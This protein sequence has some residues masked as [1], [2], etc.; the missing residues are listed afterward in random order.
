MSAAAFTATL[1]RRDLAELLAE[2]RSRTVLLVS[3]LSRTDL[4]LRPG[5]AV[6]T[7]MEELNDIVRFEDRLL[8]G[9]SSQVDADSSSYDEWFDRMVEVRQRAL[10]RL[11]AVQ[12]PDPWASI[13]HRTRMAVEH[14]YRRGEAI[15]E[16]LQLLGE[17]YRAPRRTLLPRG[18]R[19]ADPGAMTR[20]PGG[21]VELGAAPGTLT[22]PDE[23]PARRLE[24][25]PFWMDVLPVTNGEY[26]TFMAAGGYMES[27]LWSEAGW[28]WVRATE[29]RMPAVWIWEDGAWWTRWMDQVA[30]LDLNCPVGPVSYY[31]AEAFARFVGKRLPTEVEWEVAA[32]W[33]PEFQSR[34]AYPWGNMPPSPNVANLD[35]LAFQPAAVG[36]FP[37]NIS[38]LGCYG[39]MG[40]L[41][42]WTTSAFV[43]FPGAH[44][45]DPLHPAYRADFKVLK[46]GSW[47]S[48]PGAIRSTVRRAADP[49]ARHCFSGF[50]CAHDA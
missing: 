32:S 37:G 31:E 26:A 25:E 20:F 12:E 3:P 45:T 24:I 44:L 50:R 7:V 48:R 33:D 28:E 16:T 46:G 49:A 34:R 2:A 39:L 22:W 9:D 42:E 35:Q 11:E 29:A 1:S 21:T 17:T 47:A 15:L 23:Q 40:D 5:D 10:D 19:L 36:A 4:L 13:E 41:W 30:P 14:E 38:A 27:G 6:R 43:P 8:A 18:R